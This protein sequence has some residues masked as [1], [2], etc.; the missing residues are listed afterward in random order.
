ME[1]NPAKYP[2]LD[3]KTVNRPYMD[4]IC[5]ALCR[6]A[7]SGRY[8]GGP[9]TDAFESELAAATGTRMAVGVS[10]GLDALR[11]I[12]R[13]LVG[14]GRLKPG[15]EVLVA[16]NT[17][18]ASVLAISDAG[19]TPVL[20]DAD[21]VTMN[22][23]ASAAS[24]AVTERTRAMLPVHLY[25]RVC[26][27]ERLKALAREHNLIVVEDNAQAIGARSAVSGL[28]DRSFRT[29]ALG[30][31][32]A[33][34]FYP[35]KNIGALGDA[36][37]VTTD[38]ADLAATVR[39]LANYG[40]DRRYH[41]V[42]KGFNCRLDPVQAA[43]LR[44]KLP[45]LHEVNAA[46]EAV[47]QAYLDNITNPAVALPAAAC[48][49][50]CVWHQ[51]V[52][53]CETRDDLRRYLAEHGVQTDINYPTPVHRQPCYAGEFEGQAFE[54]AERLSDTLI[55]LPVSAC[56]SP[57]DACEIAAIINRYKPAE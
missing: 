6:V 4:D 3:L 13:A 9:E 31:A 22:M 16:A 14:L 49:G 19:L 33:F 30:H 57:E 34:S 21:P 12:F 7:L 45:H 10:N 40:S 1:T 50:D 46:R 41:N 18:I 15:D 47:A 53:R 29:G 5:A 42:S 39:N 55:C 52:I 43:V 32:A 8:V 54:V 23:S 37:A 25:G 56:T 48:D 28:D 24:R 11:L 38:D 2:F 44:V 20:V 27:D 51:F 26:W 17:Y 36:G 35:T